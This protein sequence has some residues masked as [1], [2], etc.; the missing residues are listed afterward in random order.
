MPRL[1]Q[2]PR[3]EAA[4][5]VL[6][7]YD[8]LFPGRDPVAEPG[9]ATGTPGNWW[10]VFALRP[11]VFRHATDHFGM[12]GMFADASVSR[13]DP[14]VREVAILRAGFAA[15]SRFVFSQHCKAARRAGL[16][17][18][19]IAA[20]PHWAVAEVWTPLERAVLAWTDCLVYDRGR[21]PDGVFEALR[22]AMSDEDILELSYHVCGYVT[23]AVMCRALRLEYDDVPERVSEVPMPGGDGPSD[24]AGKAW[25][26]RA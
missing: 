6:R 7:F 1:R 4:P 14:A 26:E 23:H 15:G 22:A 11:Y 3:A 5:E 8:A 19:K 16:P 24:W 21:A 25:A 2:V 12:F 18:E 17:E 9:T 13:L 10:T 20:I